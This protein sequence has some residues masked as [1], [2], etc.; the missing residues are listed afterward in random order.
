MSLAKADPLALK[1]EKF[2]EFCTIFGVGRFPSGV[3][4]GRRDADAMVTWVQNVVA[5]WHSLGRLLAIRRVT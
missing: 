5:F 1:N 3:C 2:R 4:V